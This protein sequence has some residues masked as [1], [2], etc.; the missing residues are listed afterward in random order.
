[1]DGAGAS[2]PRNVGIRSM[3]LYAALAGSWMLPKLFTL[4]NVPYSIKF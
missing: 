1:V 4:S 3:I 2:Q